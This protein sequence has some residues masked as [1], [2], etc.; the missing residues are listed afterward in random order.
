MHH[1]PR[2]ILIAVDGSEQSLACVNYAAGML[3]GTKSQITLFSVLNTV[4]EAYWDLE[5]YPG[6]SH[7]VQ[8][9]HAWAVAQ[10][11]GIELFMDNARALIMK[12]RF[13]SDSV[14]VKVCDRKVGIARDIAFEAGQG[15]DALVVGRTGVSR[16]KDL[17]LGSVANKLLTRSMEV[18]LWLI[19]GNPKPGR[20]IL[21]VDRSDNAMKATEYAGKMLAGTPNRIM[22]LSVLRGVQTFIRGPEGMVMPSLDEEGIAKAVN[23]LKTAELTPVFDQV[24]GILEKEGMDLKQVSTRIITD[25]LS[26]AESIVSEAR[27]GGFET[28]VVGRRGLSRVQEFFMGRVGHKVVQ[29]AHSEAVWVIP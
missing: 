25:S 5:Q 9:L 1:E 2:K 6:Y 20:V 15:Y 13:H 11:R 27:S 18:P 8:S 14:I 19:G 23:E 10:K 29:M 24:K 21:A 4:P 17:I 16:I 7:R 3:A 26:R 28:M 12:H 22:A